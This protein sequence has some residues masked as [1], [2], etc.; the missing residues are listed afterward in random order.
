MPCDP[1]DMNGNQRPYQIRGS[2]QT[3]LSLRVQ[4][5][6]DPAFFDQLREDLRRSPEFFRHAPVVID[7][8]PIVHRPPHDLRRFVARL[9]ACQLQ[10]V[11]IQNGDARWNH[12]ATDVSIG[13]LP[14]SAGANGKSKKPMAAEEAAPS[15]A[16]EL[17]AREVVEPAMAPTAPPAT[18]TSGTM[19][20][21]HAIRG[22]QQVYAANSDMICT[23][24]VSSGAEVIAKGHLHI[25]APL[26]GRAFAGFDGDT[27]SMIFCDRLEAELV[28]IA[29]FHLVSDDME[30][31]L[32]GKRVRIRCAADGLVV[33]RIE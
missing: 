18:P 6:D 32:I 30:P 3:L 24:P 29:G 11:G 28:S 13:I 15:A 21:D 12:A 1:G 25:Y 9:R 10:P 16:E 20:V 19:L 14:E 23:A 22:G 8:Q 2:L 7:V 33:E 26:R 31:A 17:P 27:K 5:P 4:E